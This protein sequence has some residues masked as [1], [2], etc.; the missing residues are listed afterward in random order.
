MLG[1]LVAISAVACYTGAVSITNVTVPDRSA[2]AGWVYLRYSPDPTWVNRIEFRC[3]YTISPASANPPTITW[4]K[5]PFT[6]RQ[7]I[8][9]WS[10]SGEVYVHPEF[11]G[12]VSV[13]SR[14][15]PTLVLTDAKFDDWGRYWCRVTNEDQSDEFGT[16]EESLLFYYKSTVFMTKNATLTLVCAVYDYD[17]PARGGQ[18][19]FVEVDKTPVRV[20]TGGTARLHCEGWGGPLASIVWFKGPSCT[21]DGNCNVYEM[22]INK[23]AVPQP[24]PILGPG[25]V[26]V[27]PKYAG[28][29]SLDFNDGGYYNYYYP[30]LTITDIRPTDVGRYW[31]TDDAPLWYQNDL[32][33]RD[34][35]FVVVL[36]DDEAP[37]PSCDGK[38]DGMY[39]DPGDCSRYYTCSGGWLYGPVSCLTGLFFNEA[40]QV[41]D[42]PDN[43]ACA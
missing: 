4:L 20:E 14:T 43:V 16:D 41:C 18:Y 11:A 8:Y 2:A 12:R 13:P 17:V 31:C 38:A 29:A 36:L 35:Q 3:E 19:S 26:N 42:W 24:H 15:R 34:S 27:S 9:K 25:T 21:Q 22:V 40:L 30:D 28:R 5:G 33:S 37:T 10:S 1:L 6:D 32:R 23:T 7:V 39:Q